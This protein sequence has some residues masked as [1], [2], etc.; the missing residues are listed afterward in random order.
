ML[1]RKHALMVKAE[2]LN[3]PKY[4]RQID[5]I[6]KNDTIFASSK[7]NYRQNTEHYKRTINQ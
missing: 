4:A 2:V 5:R 6:E 7:V 3:C 1:N